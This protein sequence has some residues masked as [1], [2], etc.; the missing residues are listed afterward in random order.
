M[1]D[2]ECCLRC[3]VHKLWAHL[4]TQSSELW[5]TYVAARDVVRHLQSG[6]PDKQ[7]HGVL[8]LTHSV[9]AHLD[10]RYVLG[11]IV[12]VESCLAALTEV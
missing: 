1:P 7:M 6:V 9:Q 5:R 3:A 2:V 8:G 12:V 4:H 10:L 11:V